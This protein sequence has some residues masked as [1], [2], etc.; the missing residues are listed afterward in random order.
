MLKLLR[1]SSAPMRALS[2]GARGLTQWVLLPV[3][4][5]NIVADTS[6]HNMAHRTYLFAGL[7]SRMGIHSG[8]RADTCSWRIRLS[9]YLCQN[10]LTGARGRGGGLQNCLITAPPKTELSI[11]LSQDEKSTSCAAADVSRGLSCVSLGP[12]DV[13]WASRDASWGPKGVN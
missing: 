7:A 8:I 12:N 11:R 9:C 10:V 1:S 2:Y 4:M 6:R 13:G 5:A 3:S